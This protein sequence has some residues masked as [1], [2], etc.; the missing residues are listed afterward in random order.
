MIKD[1]WI[2]RRRQLLGEG[3]P[4]YLAAL[5]VEKTCRVASRDRFRFRW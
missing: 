1:T 2:L 5:K 4:L 3:H